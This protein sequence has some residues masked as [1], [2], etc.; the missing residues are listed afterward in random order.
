MYTNYISPTCAYFLKDLHFPTDQ[1][2]QSKKQSNR[3]T[4]LFL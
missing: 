3:E 4:M 2:E 1:K